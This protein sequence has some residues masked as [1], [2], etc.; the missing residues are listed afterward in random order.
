M[1]ID[2]IPKVKLFGE[3]I[4]VRAHIYNFRALSAHA[5]HTGLLRWITAFEEKPRREIV[6]HGEAEACMSFADDLTRLGYS[7][8]APNYEAVFDLLENKVLDEGVE[9]LYSG[10][11]NKKNPAVSS[12]FARL[13]NAEN[14][15]MK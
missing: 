1:L 15:C 3:E 8:F 10:R 9:L 5:D 12:A 11:K 13:L 7:A 2:G 6:V 14:G 4:V